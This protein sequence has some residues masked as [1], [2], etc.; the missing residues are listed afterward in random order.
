MLHAETAG[1]RGPVGDRGYTRSF[2]DQLRAASV[3]SP[4][5]LVQSAY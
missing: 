5:L 4:T 3:T 1:G 2:A